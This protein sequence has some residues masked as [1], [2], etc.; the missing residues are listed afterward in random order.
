MR[1]LGP[2]DER[3][4]LAAL[5]CLFVVCTA[6][7]LIHPHSFADPTV[8]DEAAYYLWGAV[9]SN[10][11]YA[12]PLAEWFG[13]QDSLELYENASGVYR[14]VLSS[15]TTTR[16]SVGA[17]NDL[18]VTVAFQDG[19]RIAGA[20]VT[21]N[22]Q[23][24]AT[25]A[26]RT[27]AADGTAV[28]LNLEPGQYGLQAAVVR[29]PGRPGDPPLDLRAGGPAAVGNAKSVYRSFLDV[30]GAVPSGGSYVVALVAGDSLGGTIAGADI[31]V[32]KKGAGAPKPAKVGATDAAG[33]FPLTL[34]AAG[35]YV[36]VAQ[37]AG[38]RGGVP[39]A[40]IVEVGGE[41]YAVNR[42]AP[43][44][45]VLLGLF[46]RAGIADGINL[47]LFA[48]AS[49]AV[50]ALARRP[51]G[52]RVAALAT[53]I[54]MTCG[55]ALLMVWLKGMADFAS[56]G[57]ALAGVALTQE[58][59]AREGRFLRPALALLA[60]L[61]LGFAVFVR[62]STVT[63]VVV[64]F[65]MFAL[66]LVRASPRRGGFRVPDAKAVRK[67]AP[68]LL[69]L[70]LGLGVPA[71][72]LMDYNATY[73]GSPFGSAYQY[74]GMIT[75]EGTGNNT[76]A[77]TTSGS[78]YENFNPERAVS[79]L[80]A[81][82]GWLLVVMPFVLFVPL[83]LWAGRRDAAVLLLILY[84]LANVVLYAFVP[85]VGVGG[86]AT[87]SIE[88]MRYFL[89]AMPAAA[90]V[91]AWLLLNR[92]TR[93]HA[94]KLL[95]AAIVVLLLLTGFAGAQ[96]GIDLQ[97]RRAAMG[98]GPGGGQPP[99]PGPMYAPATVADLFRDPAAYN[100]TL[101]AVANATFWRWVAP[102]RFLMN[103]TGA[104][105]IAVAL[106]G[107]AAPSLT[108]GDLLLVRGLFRWFDADRDGIADP[109]ELVISVKGG[110]TDSIS[111]IG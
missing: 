93:A 62:Y 34:A 76:T 80:A 85:W 17:D 41:Y 37:K 44:Y 19:A 50:Y 2:L 81:R 7:V 72:F 92:F 67:I 71:A 13:I 109:P 87:R 36:V 82:I 32:A 31:L 94:R 12:V 42:W 49:V 14:I 53:A 75:V 95:A 4:A 63:L 88:D 16:D 77:T 89:P 48:M 101:V 96:I 91:T 24:G 65:A 66:A 5:A 106:D 64:P 110:T 40:S 57:F 11:S 29:P 79:T 1:P 51:F 27:T 74:G 107:Y 60:G 33:E 52:W 103:Q 84:V 25:V 58:A 90:V 97:V 99:P 46:V 22:R 30:R 6:F 28:F 39:I 108:L 61:S 21:L 56:M 20:N 78:F 98:T 10:G 18:V 3:R 111:V 38:Q 9:Y 23:A 73:F 45:S 47:L 26:S 8:P 43:G 102:D 35:S 83:A 104:A 100:N 15:E 68:P 59:V 69:A 54:A 55:I 105:P 86:D 70:L